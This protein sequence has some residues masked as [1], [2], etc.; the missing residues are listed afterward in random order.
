MFIILR[1]QRNA[2]KIHSEILTDLLICM[3]PRRHMT[4]DAG[5]RRLLIHCRQE[6]KAVQTIWKFLRITQLFHSWT[7]TKRTL[8]PTTQTLA[9]LCLLLLYTSY[10]GNRATL[11]PFNRTGNV[12][13]AHR[14]HVTLLSSEGK[15]NYEILSKMD[16]T[17]N[18]YIKQCDLSQNDKHRYVSYK[19]KYW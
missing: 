8:F 6:G 1:N 9:H 13:E 7:D 3:W 2:N 19:S 10:Q 5:E 18:Y 17:R 15:G 11:V 4:T 16:R 12:H 14:C